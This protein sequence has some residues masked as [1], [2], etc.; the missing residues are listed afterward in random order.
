MRKLDYLGTSA[1]LSDLTDIDANY[2]FNIDSNKCPL[3]KCEMKAYKLNKYEST[4]ANVD[5]TCSNT[6][7][8]P[9]LSLSSTTPY[10]LKA[11]T[12]VL[13]GYEE[14]ICY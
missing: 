5:K 2:F 10:Y 12:N 3:T 9:S 8:A 1:T 14:G 11:K 4:T 13:D 7:S 6:A